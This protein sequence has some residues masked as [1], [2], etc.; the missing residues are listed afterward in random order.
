MDLEKIR[1][2]FPTVGNETIYMDSSCM[3]LRPYQVFEYMDNYYRKFPAC[4]GRSNHKMAEKATEEKEKAREN[5]KEF[6]GAKRTEE[7][8]FTRNSTEAI[9]IVA[10]SL[11]LS[12]G[13]KV[14]TSDREHN[15]NL[16]PW[17]V[18]KEK[19]G[20]EHKVVDPHKD[21]T[22]DMSEFE[23]LLD[24]DVELVSIVHK[25][26]LDGYTLP[27]EKIIDKAHEN[28]A[29]VL[30]D[31]AQSAPHMETDLA[32]LDVDFYAL[33]SHKACGPSG[34]GALYGKRRLLEKLDP[35]ITGGETVGNS[36]Y[37]SAE[38]RK[39]P[40]KFEAGLQNIPG[41]MGFG[42]ACE[43][44]M[45]IGRE[46]IRRHE[47]KLTERLFSC[48]EDLDYL[49]TVGVNDPEKA[50]GMLNFRVKGMTP[51]ETSILLDDRYN[52]ATR[53]GMHCLHSWFNSRDINGSTRASLYLYNS[54]EEVETLIETL[55]KIGSIV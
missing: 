10:N 49:E 24:E 1:N 14:I 5:V 17:Q 48:A 11:N 52:I 2:D 38:F 13:D 42:R 6:L 22:F 55:K 18:L 8:V 31:G 44:L 41:I 51:H 37:T 25:S 3:S 36:T 12:E 54:L 40:E 45:D 47:K 16:V 34:M 4:S 15:S 29:K 35:F 7:V 30:V 46:E 19:K 39:P 53:S 9:N 33:S 32:E 50:S 23:E 21:E 27:V 26:N 43:Y 20:V 28:G